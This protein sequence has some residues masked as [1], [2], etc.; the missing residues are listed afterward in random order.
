VDFSE[1]LIGAERSR[2]EFLTLELDLAFS[3][4][5]LAQQYRDVANRAR[6]LRNARTALEA[7]RHFEGKIGDPGAW[8][9]IHARADEL[10]RLLG[11]VQINQSAG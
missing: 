2:I 1:L 6:S 9:Q 11:S 5:S 10:E 7:I 4:V 8:R 3:F